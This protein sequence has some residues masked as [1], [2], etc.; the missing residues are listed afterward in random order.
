MIKYLH[1]NNI[2]GF[3]S[4]ELPFSSFNLLSGT[5]GV[6]KSTIIQSLLLRSQIPERVG[7]STQNIFHL[8]LDLGYLNLGLSGDMIRRGRTSNDI[9]I[10]YTHDDISLNLTVIEEKDQDYL[11]FYI[12]RKDWH[13]LNLQYLN[14]ERI[15]PRTTYGSR[16]LSIQE[17]NRIN[18]LGA[19]GELTSLYLASKP[20]KEIPQEMLDLPPRVDSYKNPIPY[21]LLEGVNVWLG[22]IKSGT[23]IV[24]KYDKETNQSIIRFNG[25]NRP[26]NEGFG[27]SVV[28]PIIVLV[29]AAPEKST[30]VIENPEAHLHPSGQYQIGKL[31]CMAAKLGHQVIIETHSDHILNSLRLAVKDKILSRD[32]VS[33]LHFSKATESDSSEVNSIGIDDS[34]VLLETS[35]GFFDEYTKRLRELW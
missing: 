14:A 6:G 28:L 10:K 30:L 27:L 26:V 19:F 18:F 35:E 15:G 12:D 25:V 5:N 8:P 29:L 3:A 17:E 20:T 33:I 9:F 4:A 13:Q 11:S 2:K 31:L 7:D 16:S 21:T 23:T 32:N 34:G 1:L 24:S 22:R